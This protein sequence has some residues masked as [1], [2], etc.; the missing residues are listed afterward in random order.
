MRKPNNVWH[1]F[2]KAGHFGHRRDGFHRPRHTGLGFETGR[3]G[4]EAVIHL[5]LVNSSSLIGFVVSRFLAA[6]DAGVGDEPHGVVQCSFTQRGQR[7]G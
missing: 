3:R 5:W 1:G 7:I 2:G 6:V 4:V